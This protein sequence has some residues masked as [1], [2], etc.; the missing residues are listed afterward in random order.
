VDFPAINVAFDAPGFLAGV[1]RSSVREYVKTAPELREQFLD[2]HPGYAF[3]ADSDT[4]VL[5]GRAILIGNRMYNVFIAAKP[6]AVEPAQ[7]AR[8]LASLRVDT[9]PSWAPVK[10][11]GEFAASFPAAPTLTHDNEKTTTW[12]VVYEGAH[13]ALIQIRRAVKPVKSE[14]KAR[15]EL[16]KRVAE[17]L[18]GTTVPSRRVQKVTHEGHPAVAYQATTSEGHSIEGRYLLVGTDIYI[19]NV[20]WTGNAPRERIDEFLSA[21]QPE[22]RPLSL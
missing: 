15:Q 17:L 13:Y 14:T 4:L 21:F 6:G 1:V 2:G 19:L 5:A 18:K 10:A 22:K 3:R 7:A 9:S 11:E 16:N 20:E 8:F 12:S